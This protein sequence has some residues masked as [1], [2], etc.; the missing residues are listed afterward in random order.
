MEAL[1]LIHKLVPG[2]QRRY[3]LSSHGLNRS[4]D[5][6]LDGLDGSKRRASY[7]ANSELRAIKRLKTVKMST[8][9]LTVSKV[10][11]QIQLVQGMIDINASS[12]NSLRTQF[13]TNSDLIQQEIR[14][15]E[16]KLVKLFSRQLVAKQKCN[17]DWNDCEKLRYYPKLEQWLQVVGINEEAIKNLEEKCSTV[18]GLLSLSDE[19]VKAMLE[20]YAEGQEESRR[21][22]AALKHLQAYTERQK[23]G[24]KDSTSDIYW[25]S[26]D[27]G[28]T[29]EKSL[30]ISPSERSSRSSVTLDS[31]VPLSSP[32]S[33]ADTEGSRLSTLSASDTD[34]TLSPKHIGNSQPAYFSMIKRSV[35]D[36]ANLGNRIFVNNNENPYLNC[37]KKRG[38]KLEPVTPLTINIPKS[39]SGDISLH[40]QSDSESDHNLSSH[41]INN[42]PS[43]ITHYGMGHTI[44]HRFSQKAF[45]VSLACDHC[46]KLLLVGVKCKYCKLKFHKKCAKKA[47]AS[48]GLPKGCSDFFTAQ[49][50]RALNYRSLPMTRSHVKRTN[51]EPSSIALQVDLPEQRFNQNRSHGDLHTVDPKSWTPV[52]NETPK[53][54]D[55]CSTSSSTS[56]PPSSP[57]PAA[58]ANVSLSAQE[59]LDQFPE[60]HFSFTDV[61]RMTASLHSNEMIESTSTLV[62]TESVKSRQSNN[63]TT[64][65]DSTL[66]GEDVPGIDSL[67][68]QI[69]DVDPESKTWNRSRVQRGSLMSEWVIPFE[70]LNITGSPLGSGRFGKVYRGHWHGEVAVKM[71]EIENPTEEQLNAFKFQVGTFR[72]TRHENVVLFMGACMDP[73]K[74]AIITSM[75]RGF[76]LYTHIH[77]RKDSFPLDKI[78]QICTQI[79][80]GMG[81]LHAR[82]IVHTDLRSKNVFLE[83][84]NRVVITDFGLF[85]VAGLTTKSVRPGFLMIP[86]GWLPYLAPEI[87]RSLTT[88]QDAPDSS[89]FTMATDMYAFGTV[90]YEMCSRS[91]PFEKNIP[92]SIIWQVGKGVKQSLANIDIPREVKDTLTVCWAFE[93]DRRPTFG[94]LLRTLERLPKIRHTQRLHRSPSQPCTVGRGAENL[95]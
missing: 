19:K 79:S 26:W 12:L 63:T 38:G 77:V 75:C 3:R 76:S 46:H 27:T 73:P 29:R 48:C 6:I 7:P 47:T 22:I 52:P 36:D 51:S 56:S 90:W 57:L 66:S 53:G 13:S 32:S 45:M 41:A 58:S 85:S 88:Q 69:S 21:L 91:W 65:N 10:L 5:S 40:S 49:V 89:Q 94:N 59:E 62:R 8:N 84:Y 23:Q 82:G 80:Q 9:G 93:P 43:R 55:S 81:Y 14:T 86:Q 18:E 67:D 28:K 15:L 78:L 74:L 37:G 24:H 30:S 95:I 87:L 33:D 39:R 35:S 11:E 68:S 60:S 70:E 64:S 54:V 20:N 61:S 92:E 34:S 2:R 50:R 17:E 16:G 72:K 4:V 83:S 31:D 44:S 71:I 25:D 42:S 1:H